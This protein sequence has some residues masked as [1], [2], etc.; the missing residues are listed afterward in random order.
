MKCFLS[1]LSSA[2]QDNPRWFMVDVKF[3]RKTK[4]YISLPEL[5]SIHQEHKANGGPLAKVALFTR[6]RLSVQPLTKGQGE[7]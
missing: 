2:K 5:K 4:R 7:K 6:A 3:V 1:F